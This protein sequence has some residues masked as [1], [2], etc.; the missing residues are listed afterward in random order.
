MSGVNFKS[1]IMHEAGKRVLYGFNTSAEGR[2]VTWTKTGGTLTPITKA[3]YSALRIPQNKTTKHRM[4]RKRKYN[5]IVNL[6][7]WANPRPKKQKVAKNRPEK[8]E[9]MVLYASFVPIYRPLN[10]IHAEGRPTG[11]DQHPS[12]QSERGQFYPYH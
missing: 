6:G 7:G 11:N 2:L 12:A 3:Q 5:P 1:V 9:N 4:G 8:K 10:N